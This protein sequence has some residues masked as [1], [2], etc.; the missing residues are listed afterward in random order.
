MWFVFIQITIAIQ[1]QSDMEVCYPYTE[2]YL[3]KLTFY[4]A[5]C[6][7]LSQSGVLKRPHRIPTHTVRVRVT[8]TEERPLTFQNLQCL[9]LSF[10]DLYYRLTG[11]LYA[12]DLFHLAYL[13]TDFLS[14]ESYLPA[15]PTECQ[16]PS[17][18]GHTRNTRSCL[19]HQS[20]AEELQQVSQGEGESCTPDWMLCDGSFVPSYPGREWASINHGGQDFSRAFSSVTW[21]DNALDILGR[22]NITD[23]TVYEQFVFSVDVD[24]LHPDHSDRTGLISVSREPSHSPRKER[25]RYNNARGPRPH[26]Q[27]RRRYTG[28]Y[29]ANS[30]TKMEKKSVLST[31]VFYEVYNSIC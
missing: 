27:S 2:R 24:I 18:R 20:V 13:Q 19:E 4:A 5:D 26:Q 6:P 9:S 21:T 30:V 29:L 28:A 1:L 23:Y 8:N 7:V 10:P 15:R 3:L 31:E 25:T 11:N 22:C 14:S 12:P 16:D 17:Y